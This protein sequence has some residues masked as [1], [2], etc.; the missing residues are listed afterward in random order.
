MQ[1]GL[2]HIAPMQHIIGS[3][4]SYVA[5]SS[6]T[7]HEACVVMACKGSGL[8][9]VNYRL[10]TNWLNCDA[11]TPPAGRVLHPF[12]FNSICTDA[13]STVYKLWTIVDLLYTH[14]TAAEQMKVMPW[15][16]QAI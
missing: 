11:Y 4:L 9:E 14:C 13:P 1:C 12:S 5:A 7:I 3:K 10:L 15:I 2:E 8:P 6:L 16:L